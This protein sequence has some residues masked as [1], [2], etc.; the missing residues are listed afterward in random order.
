MSCLGDDADVPRHGL[1]LGRARR[2]WETVQY[3][4]HPLLFLT[5][6]SPQSS[7]APE[8]F[9]VKRSFGITKG[10]AEV[11]VGADAE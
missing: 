2:R 7:Q 4:L 3:A 5:L 8:W 6:K 10:R 1:H 9:G 11:C